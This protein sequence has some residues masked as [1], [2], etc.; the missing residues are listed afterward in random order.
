[1]VSSNISLLETL[2]T[3]KFRILF[4]LIETMNLEIILQIQELSSLQ[5]LSIIA[6]QSP[7]DKIRS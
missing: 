3:N 6:N 2:F 4:P 1:M 5:N 7:N